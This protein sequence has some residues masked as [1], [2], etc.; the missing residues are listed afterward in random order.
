MTQEIPKISNLRLKVMLPVLIGMAVVAWLFYDEFSVSSWSA[1]K[2]GPHALV[3]IAL[4]LVFVV[5]RDFGLT[6]R[7]H[8]IASPDLSWRRALRVDLMC[9]FTSAITPSV[10]GG[11]AFAIFYLNREGV[12]VGRGTTLT[13][14]TLFL[15]E[16]FFVVFCPIIVLLMPLESLFGG[17]AS[18]VLDG[19]EVVFWLVYAGI[20]VWTAILF[21]GIIV[22]PGGVR[23]V[24][25]GLFKKKLLRRWLPSI[26]STTANM[27]ETSHWVK[28]CTLGWWIRVFLATVVSWFSRY[29]IVNALFWAFVPDSSPVLV[30]CRQFV[31]WVVLMVSPT[32]GGSG[33][34]EWIF[35]Q[36]YGDIIGSGDLAVVMALIWRV[37]TYYIYLVIGMIIIPGYFKKARR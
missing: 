31:V 36:Y 16:L 35:A 13:L 34:S 27:V 14:T 3:G 10:V 29:L 37:I 26:E 33:L 28:S 32:P 20:V 6:W 1:I 2:F 15:D 21:F 7:F 22:S 30:F 19:I 9:A 25:V 18:P 11:S 4:A 5:G 24:L 8:T 23:R 12:D 17:N